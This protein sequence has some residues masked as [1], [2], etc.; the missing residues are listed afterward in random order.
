MRVLVVDD[1]QEFVATLVKRLSRRGMVCSTAFTGAEAIEI[2][3]GEVFDV[4][5]L[6][7]KLPDIDGNEVLREMKKLK[8]K[9]QVVILTGHIS[10]SDGMEGIGCGAND[11]LMKPV[12][13][14]SLLESLQLAGRSQGISE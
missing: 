6:D 5:L 13:F 10:A 7:M 2:V 4:V 14:E 9:T 3:R 1:E 12:E 11:Y 8:P